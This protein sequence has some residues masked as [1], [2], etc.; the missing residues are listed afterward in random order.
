MS[1]TI[2][3][4]SNRQK[5]ELLV[6][7]RSLQIALPAPPVEVRDPLDWARSVFPTD[8]RALVRSAESVELNVGPGVGIAANKAQA[9][10]LAELIGAICEQGEC[11]FLI[12][13]VA[14]VAVL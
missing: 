5:K 12:C 8:L 7:G 6:R 13:V 9:V 4:L 10:S 11:P 1:K 2:Y 14:I 3:Y